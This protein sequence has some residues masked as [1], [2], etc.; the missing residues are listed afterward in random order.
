MQYSTSSRAIDVLGF[1]SVL[2]L[3]RNIRSDKKSGRISIGISALISAV[4]SVLT[5]YFTNN[6]SQY[7]SVL[8]LSIA[9]ILVFVFAFVISSH[10][11]KSYTKKII[12]AFSFILGASGLCVLPITRGVEALKAKPVSYAIQEIVKQNPD[13]KWLGGNFVIA[14]GGSSIDSTNYIPNMDLWTKLDPEGLYENVYNRYAH[15]GIKFVDDEP[16][17]F[18][19][20]AADTFILNLNYADIKMRS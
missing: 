1:I 20:T 15:V 3:I 12:L 17:S 19:L 7:M 2:L 10:N 11:F 8:E 13:K 9:T 16:T 5:V 4:T 6:A 14:N 18:S